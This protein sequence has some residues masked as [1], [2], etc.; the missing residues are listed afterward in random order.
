MTTVWSLPMFLEM[1][2]Y[3]TKNKMKAVYLR[4]MWVW[5]GCCLSLP[6]LK[7]RIDYNIFRIVRF[8]F[9]FLP[10]HK[11][12]LL[13]FSSSVPQWPPNWMHYLQIFGKITTLAVLT[14]IQWHFTT[15]VNDLFMILILHKYLLGKAT[16][17]ILGCCL[18]SL[19]FLC[20]IHSIHSVLY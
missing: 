1:A 2:A 18:V 15:G 4:C 12:P 14:G 3:H 5:K 20:D 16:Y 8:I 13:S 6:S 10:L 17:F 11:W 19:R 9:F 7:R